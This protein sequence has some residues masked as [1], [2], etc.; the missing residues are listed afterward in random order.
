MVRSAVAVSLRLA[1]G[2]EGQ[3]SAPLPRGRAAL[4]GRRTGDKFEQSTVGVVAAVGSCRGDVSAEDSSSARPRRRTHRGA[5]AARRHARLRR[6]VRRCE[7]AGRL[8]EDGRSPAA[9][10]SDGQDGQPLEAAMAGSA[11]QEAAGCTECTAQEE[12]EAVRAASRLQRRWR[13]RQVAR[14]RTRIEREWTGAR[15]RRL[16]PIGPHVR[17]LQYIFRRTRL[18]R[19]GCWRRGQLRG[20]LRVVL[21]FIRARLT[22]ETRCDGGRRLA[23]EADFASQRARAEQV[24]DWYRQYVQ[25]LRRLM[26]GETPTVLQL[27]CG[28]GGSTEG[29]RRGGGASHGVDDC[30]QADYERRF[31][32]GSVTTGDATDWSLVGGLRKAHRAVGAIGGPPCKP[33]STADFEGRSRAPAKRWRLS[34][35]GGPRGGACTCSCTATTS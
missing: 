12:P 2:G 11:L 17:Y 31:G 8:Q 21:W 6:H 1:E 22:P 30:E 34:C 28:G 33:Y 3:G 25:L 26:S 4:G 7:A 35:G 23:T 24:L 20:P 29:V 5:P 27:F 14:R 9:A 15:A 18:L 16:G 32:R 10:A 13:A 19:P